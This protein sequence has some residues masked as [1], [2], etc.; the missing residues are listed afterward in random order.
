MVIP[1]TSAPYTRMRLFFLFYALGIVNLF[2]EGSGTI[3]GTVPLSES[4]KLDVPV[5]KYRGKISGKVDPSPAVVAAVWLESDRI[6]APKKPPE[7]TIAQQNYQ[8]SQYLVIIPKGGKI[9]FP[10]KD[11]DYHN[12]YSLSKTKRFDLGRYKSSETPFPSVVF[13][14]VGFVRLNCEIHDHMKAN[15][16]VVDSPY[17]GTTN[18]LGRFSLKNIPAGDYILHAQMDRKTKWQMPI[19]VLAGKTLKINFPK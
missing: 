3:T 17:Y 10:N 13:D 12:I 11:P 14:K 6:S 15:V 4:K 18:Q 7:V 19:K 1:F 9:F 16:V 2:A 8:F 5:G